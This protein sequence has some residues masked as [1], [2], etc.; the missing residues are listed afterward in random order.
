MYHFKKKFPNSCI[1]ASD[2]AHL[3]TH[4]AEEWQMFDQKIIGWTINQWCTRIQAWTR[5]Y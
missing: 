1:C 2:V 5:T 3:K 4:L